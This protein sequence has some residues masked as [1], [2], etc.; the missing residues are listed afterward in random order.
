MTFDAR[1]ARARAM[2]SPPAAK[3]PATHHS[4][5]TA[6]IASL[7]LQGIGCRGGCRRLET[8]AAA[9][10]IASNT[11]TNKFDARRIKCGYELHERIDIAAN[12]TVACLHSLDGR[13]RQA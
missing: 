3:R 13:Y 12:D 7:I 8:D 9:A 5:S 10:A 4:I 6:S 11:F 2:A 1:P